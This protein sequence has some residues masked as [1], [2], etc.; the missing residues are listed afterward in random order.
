MEGLL[1]L[2]YEL[3]KG[4]AEDLTK[5]VS[6]AFV[7]ETTLC[8]GTVFT[9]A[10]LL[11]QVCEEASEISVIGHA[12]SLQGLYMCISLLAAASYSAARQRQK[13]TQIQKE[14]LCNGT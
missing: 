8:R 7:I 4:Y 6:L 2:G 3:S 11:Y 9:V 5:G 10:R 1:G 13:P 12:L 14:T